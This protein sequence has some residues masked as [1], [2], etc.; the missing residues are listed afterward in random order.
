MSP[1]GSHTLSATIPPL[2]TLSQAAFT[3]RFPTLSSHRVHSGQR[4][5]QRGAPRNLEPLSLQPGEQGSRPGGSSRGLVRETP[6]RGSRV[7]LHWTMQRNPCCGGWVPHWWAAAPRPAKAYMAPG[8]GAGGKSSFPRDGSRENESPRR[9]ASLREEAGKSPPAGGHG[10]QG[11]PGAWGRRHAQWG[12]P[13]LPGAAVSWS[14][15]P[16]GRAGGLACRGRAHSS[17]HPQEVTS[18][19]SLQGGV[20]ARILGSKKDGQHASQV[21]GGGPG[22]G[23]WGCR[24]LGLQW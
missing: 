11:G 3:A 24:W 22:V 9:P 10:P 14:Q 13:H 8:P 19:H 16:G 1:D 5:A 2:P 7:A 23:I 18:S 15:P 21:V 20:G 12:R 4:Q 6:V 17:P